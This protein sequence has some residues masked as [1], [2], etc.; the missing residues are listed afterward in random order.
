[1]NFECTRKNP[2]LIAI[3]NRSLCSHTAQ[4][5]PERIT[6]L[7]QAGFSYI[8][9]R[10]K[11]LSRDEYVALLDDIARWVSPAFWPRIILHSYS[12]AELSKSTLTQ[13]NSLLVSFLSCVAGFHLTAHQLVSTLAETPDKENHTNAASSLS[14]DASRTTVSVRDTSLTNTSMIGA[15]IKFTGSCISIRPR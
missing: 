7:C 1:M 10:E 6:H 2:Q 14:F 8:I 4:T 5:L 3:T 11:D 12:P 13:R 15:H 9:V